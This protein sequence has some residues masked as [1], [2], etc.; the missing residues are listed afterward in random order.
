MALADYGVAVCHKNKVATP[1]SS[2]PRKPII[3][4]NHSRIAILQQ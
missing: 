2:V 1:L 3:G 4:C